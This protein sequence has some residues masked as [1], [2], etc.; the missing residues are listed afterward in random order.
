MKL[1]HRNTLVFFTV[2]IVISLL[3]TINSAKSQSAE[4]EFLPFAATAFSGVNLNMHSANFFAVPGF[5][6][7]G[8]N[9]TNGLGLG[10]VV[11]IG[12]EY[13]P[14]QR[15]F[16]MEYRVGGILLFSTLS[17][18]LEK[19]DFIGN[20][21]QGNNASKA[22]VQTSIN[23]SLSA[24][25]AEPYIA[26]YPFGDS[27]A[28]VKMGLQAGIP[29][30]A[31]MTR[32]EEL[33]APDGV[34]FETG[35]RI[36]NEKTGNIPDKSSLYTA[37]VVALRYDVPLG[38]NTILIPEAAFCFS[39]N[40]ISSTL[41]WKTNVL[42][43]GLTFAY[44]PN[45]PAPEPVSVPAPVIVPPEPKEKTL[46]LAAKM[47]INGMIYFDGQIITIP[48][49][50]TRITTRTSL[51]HV[52]YFAPQSDIMTV[53]NESAEASNKPP[54]II[55]AVA[56]YLRAN[57][58]SK[59]TVTTYYADD[60]TPETAQ[61]RGKAIVEAL[62]R[63]NADF[64]NISVV[65]GEI[66]LKMK[67]PDMREE[68]R[69]ATFEING[70][71]IVFPYTASEQKIVQANDVIVE[72]KPEFSASELPVIVS[73]KLY[74]SGKT[75]ANLDKSVT[76]YIIN[77]QEFA[78]SNTSKV[79]SAEYTLKD[80]AGDIKTSTVRVNIQPAPNQTE[81]I[82]NRDE[83]GGYEQ[84][85]IGYFDF[86]GAEF[87]SVDTFSIERVRTAL[88]N[89]KSVEIIGLTDDLGAEEYNKKLA[90][91]RIM[92]ALNLLGISENRVTTTTLLPIFPRNSTPNSRTLN[93]SVVVRIH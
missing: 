45:E 68:M 48:V 72:T 53:E 25:L 61:K 20:V 81:E 21:I 69:R 67:R 80:A 90:R 13:F 18:R 76:K 8:S 55:E 89:G 88:Q 6:G 87:S 85:I 12:T 66:P 65:Q 57:P 34:N 38:R 40:D 44:H 71:P 84:Y 3:F 5:G 58:M 17:G 83:K 14:K 52:A 46:K 63:N 35:N 41:P 22:L 78:S 82:I 30:S 91:Q 9:F 43:A 60:E 73:G 51:A 24:V 54:N 29:I 75:V 79:I 10:S 36:R 93:R 49:R 28:S 70:K 31:T 7:Y 92:S 42:R 4:R 86:D 27:P 33:I 32:R 77:S 19:Q 56:A 74:F 15:L 2:F 16:G 64:G 26:F 50:E 23:A 62:R 39:L 37:G 47:R 1:F 11:G 59:L